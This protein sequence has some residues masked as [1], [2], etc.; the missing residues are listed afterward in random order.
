MNTSTDKIR[1]IVL[2]AFMIGIACSFKLWISDRTFPLCPI[3]DCFLVFP[4]VVN[5]LLLLVFFS[6]LV[7][8]F[9]RFSRRL[10]GFALL[11]L[12][13]LVLQDQNRIQPW[14]YLYGLILM[15]FLSVEKKYS[16]QTTQILLLCLYLW[17]GLH[18]LNSTFLEVDF[19]RLFCDFFKNT[20]PFIVGLGKKMAF[21]FPLREA[22]C[23]FLLFL[24]PTRQLGFWVAT[25][26][27][28]SIILVLSPW[29]IAY[30][31][32]VIPWNMAIIALN[33]FVFYKNE[34]ALK[35]NNIWMYLLLGVAGVL[36]IFNFFHRFD[37]MLSHSLY[38]SKNKL[39]YIGVAQKYW[40]KLP[41]GFEK[42]LLPL[43]PNTEG[44]YLI[45]VNK[46]AMY[47]LNV[48]V[49]PE[50]RIFKRI[51]ASFCGYAIPDTDLLFLIYT[52]PMNEGN[53]TKWRCGE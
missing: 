4:S 51:S 12:L 52:Q 36:P 16:V 29:G 17:S 10:L 50:Y 8:L 34:A 30:N 33:Y 15:S 45:D 25:F 46:W 26:I 20:T 18:K 39:F 31:N 19:P 53:L 38:D 14:V 47:E 42:V 2:L 1:G 3:A 35:I 41:Q 22:S 11:L 5:Y 27:H 13:F 24:K 28:L 37:D 23:A 40:S 32:I 6:S 48:P 49:N 43:P 44:G 21:L 7:V 9:F